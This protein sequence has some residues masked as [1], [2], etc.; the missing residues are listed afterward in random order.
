[1]A[2]IITEGKIESP[3]QKIN[4]QGDLNF[5]P[6]KISIKAFKGDHPDPRPIDKLFFQ[7]TL[8]SVEGG[9]A[10]FGSVV[11]G[12]RKKGKQWEITNKADS[13]PNKESSSF[14]K[15]PPEAYQNSFSSPM[16]FGSVE[17]T[18]KTKNEQIEAFWKKFDLE[19]N[20]P[21]TV[22]ELRLKALRHENPHSYYEITLD[23]GTGTLSSEITVTSNP[24]PPYP[25]EEELTASGS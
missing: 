2:D 10:N 17:L 4:S 5:P 16:S 1:M 14:N 11:Y 7:S 18:R 8:L 3:P 20:K 21:D 24:C 9:V 19:F 6:Q 22:A 15:V 23:D 25:P 13:V 12:G